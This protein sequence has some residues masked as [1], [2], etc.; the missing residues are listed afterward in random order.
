MTWKCEKTILFRDS[1]LF[2][3]LRWVIL[4][5]D[6]GKFGIWERCNRRYLPLTGELKRKR[7]VF[8]NSDLELLSW[9]E[10]SVFFFFNLFHFFREFF[11][12]LRDKMIKFE[13]I[14]MEKW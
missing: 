5:I 10:S 11:Y 1:V 3:C 2:V 9:I 4:R 14:N 13:S 7:C 8:Y 6:R 12:S